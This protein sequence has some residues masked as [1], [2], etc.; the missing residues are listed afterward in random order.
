M[1]GGYVTRDDGQSWHMFNLRGVINVFAFDPADPKVIYAGNAALWRSSDSGR[2][3]KMF[4]P[5][6]A[7][8]T[9]EHQ[10]GDHSDY[11]LT[12]SDPAYPAGDITAIAIAKPERPEH[13]YLAF[14]YRGHRLSIRAAVALLI[15]MAT[16]LVSSADGGVSWKPPRQFACKRV[17]LLAHSKLR[18]DCC[19]G[20]CGLAHRPRWQHHRIG[21]HRIPAFTAASAAR[22]G[23]SVWI[24]ATGKDGKVYLSKDSG[25]HLEPGYTRRSDR[26]PASF[27]AIAASDLH[28]EVAYVGF[29]AFKWARARQNLFNGIA[30]T[31]DGGKTWKIVFKESNQACR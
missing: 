27:E 18:P 12:S 7:R 15:A 28:P 2:T 14:R 13:L 4:F 19:L 11:S 22:S 25:L 17:Q 20:L 5:S 30:K 21:Q 3:W 31:T 9:V 8:N 16:V 10:I 29:E 1:T 26:A 6:P 23:G 24:Y